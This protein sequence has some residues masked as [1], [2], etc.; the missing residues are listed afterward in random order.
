MNRRALLIGAGA[1]LALLVLWYF[2]LWSPAGG[3]LTAARDRTAAA[4]AQ[5][6]AL[7]LEIRRLQDAHRK[8]PVKRATLESLRVAIPDAPQ[9]GQL[10][11]EINDAANRSGIS[12]LSIAPTPP[13]APLAGGP[14]QMALALSVAGGYFQVLDFINR[15]DDMP[16]LI[17]ID[18]LSLAPNPTTGR[19]SA[20]IAG[21]AFV[22]A[23]TT[24]GASVAP[25][26]P[27]AAPPTTAPPTTVAP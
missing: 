8:E 24:A 4:E 11:L 3:R 23:V 2:L 6:Q 10:I 5:E 18:S 22:A 7:T 13:A 15:L 19:I 9:P 16:R 26:P 17:V 27:P 14:P 12:F 20:Q 25:P 21:R 1:A